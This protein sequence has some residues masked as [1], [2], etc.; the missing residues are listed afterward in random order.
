[1]L[2]V[3]GSVVRCGQAGL[4]VVL[5]TARGSLADGWSWSCFRPDMMR[6]A[7]PVS[8]PCGPCGVAF[9]QPG[10]RPPVARFW[11]LWKQRR[12]VKPDRLRHAVPVHSL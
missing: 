10:Q 3:P 6:S 9:G 5:G 2:C 11:R 4:A 7:R 1:M 8:R 12:N